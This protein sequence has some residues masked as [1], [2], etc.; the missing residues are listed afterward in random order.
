LTAQEE[1]Q[2]AQRIERGRTRVRNLP[3]QHPARRRTD[4]RKLIE[5]G[6]AA[7]E[8]LITANSRLV[9]SVA[10]KYMGRGVPFLDLIQEGNIGLI[11]ATKN[12]ITGEATSFQNLCHV[13]DPPGSDARHRRP[14]T[15][16]PCAGAHGRPD[17]QAA[18]RQ[19]QLTQRL[20]RD[21]AWKNWAK[22]LGCTPKSREMIQV[23]AATL[24]T[25]KRPQTNE[26][27]FGPGRFHRRR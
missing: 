21:P 5:D 23:G 18:A 20:G 27:D 3:R 1:V 13:V 11:R 24:V 2:L 19:H 17:Q 12:S 15:N 14:G 7:R 6:W 8:H 4:L 22:A 25:P 10:K 26:E 16:D 9:I